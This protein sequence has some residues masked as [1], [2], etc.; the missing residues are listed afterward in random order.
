MGDVKGK[1]PVRD[2]RDIRPRGLTVDMQPPSFRHSLKYE[3]V[4][5]ARSP[6]SRQGLI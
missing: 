6:Q 1:D 2:N 4:C 3:F 5:D